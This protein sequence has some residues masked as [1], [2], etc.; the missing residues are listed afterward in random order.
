MCVMMEKERVPLHKLFVEI[1]EGHMH[2]SSQDIITQVQVSC[3]LTPSII[4]VPGPS[5]E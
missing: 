2:Q 4:V 1:L 5:I 3:S